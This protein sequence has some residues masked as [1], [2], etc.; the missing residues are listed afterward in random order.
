V[1]SYRQTLGFV[2]TGTCLLNISSLNLSLPFDAAVA[3]CTCTAFWGQ[4]RLGELLPISISVSSPISLPLRSGFKRSIRNPQS[5]ILHLPHTKTHPHGEEVILID[6]NDP[7]NPI[8]LLKNHIRVNGIPKD[9]LL[10]SFKESGCL[11]VMD[12][13]SFLRRCNDIWRP[14]GHPRLT[15]HSFRIGGTTELLIAGT[16]PEVVRVTGRWSSESFLRY[17]RSLEDIAPHYISNLPTLS[18]RRNR[19]APTRS[20]G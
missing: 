10:F 4:C 12:K 3:A 2:V 18:R 11:V 6:Q 9:G 13:T 19:F 17:W 15:G 16:H 8:T 20:M 1:L 14:L 5:C 7:V